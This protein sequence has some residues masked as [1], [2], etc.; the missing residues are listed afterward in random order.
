M[1]TPRSRK[2][3]AGLVVSGAVVMGI[4]TASS[5]NSV[6]Q[7]GSEAVTQ[8]TGELADP[9]LVL[10]SKG[11]AVGHIDAAEFQVAEGS[12][13]DP[14][15]P[16]PGSQHV[17]RGFKVQNDAGEL[18]GYSLISLGYHS[19]AEV[20]TPG[21]IDGLIAEHEALRAKAMERFGDSFKE[22]ADH[23]VG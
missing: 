4:A 11:T 13:D 1:S 19:L 10:D 20:N 14:I 3:F 8:V 17:V 5:S 21:L 18:I 15:V 16:V 12:A 23:A 2:C 9:Y 22:F 6:A 7:P